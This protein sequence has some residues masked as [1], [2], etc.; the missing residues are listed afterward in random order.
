MRDLM[1]V[2]PALDTQTKVR[3]RSGV[4]QASVQR[5]LSCKQSATLDL[6]QQ[7]SPAF[8]CSRPDGLLLEADELELL[9]AWGELSD[10]EKQSVLGY[11]RVTAQAKKAQLNIDSGRPVPAQ[12]QAAQKASAARPASHE[13]PLENASKEKRSRKS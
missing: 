3:D 1:R 4:S 11:I 12:L 2:N 13:A 7:L 5:I 9:G 6:L 10:A 8:G